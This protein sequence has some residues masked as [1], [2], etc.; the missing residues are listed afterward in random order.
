LLIPMG[1]DCNGKRGITP[2]SFG[3]AAK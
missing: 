2:K 1:K 3:N